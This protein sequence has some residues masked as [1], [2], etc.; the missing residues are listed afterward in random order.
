MKNNLETG[1]LRQCDRELLDACGDLNIPAVLSAIE[2]GADVNVEYEGCTPMFNAMLGD[3]TPPADDDDDDD[4]DGPSL[5]DEEV[6]ASLENTD[7]Q[8]IRV[9][10]ILLSHGAGIN[11]IPKG[12]YELLW[13]SVHNAPCVTE[14]LLKNGADPNLVSDDHTDGFVDT[15]L[16]HAWTDET[17]YHDDKRFAGY[18]TKIQRLLL[19]YGARPNTDRNITETSIDLTKFRSF[20][21]VPP[22]TFPQK[23][24]ALPSLSDAEKSLFKAC[25]ALDVAAVSKLLDDGCNPNI[26]DCDDDCATPLCKVTEMQAMGYPSIL[27]DKQIDHEVG[28]AALNGRAISIARELL[29]HGADPNIPKVEQEREE[30]GFEYLYGQTPLMLAA[31][32]SKNEEMTELLL[33]SGANPNF[34]CK[35]RDADGDTI[36]SLNGVDYHVDDPMEVNKIEQLLDCY[37]GCYNGIFDDWEFSLSDVDQALIYACQRLD[38]YGV[39]LAAKLGGDLAVHSRLGDCC[40]PVVAIY[41]APQLLGNRVRVQKWG[42]IESLVTDFVL[43]LLVGMKT[44]VSEK[45]VDAILKA[46]V[47]AGFEELMTALLSHHSLGGKFRDA[48]S[49]CRPDEYL[50]L[51]WPKD[52]R[53]RMAR[54]LGQKE[55]A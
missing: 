21:N 11:K 16:D 26:R 53:E 1:A 41:D 20:E 6:C 31:W 18:F 51:K 43:F 45:D 49:T 17:V 35:D 52:K 5:S 19:S 10:E 23:P 4:D 15:P 25:S 33:E 22:E 54:L 39:Q 47:S 46:C 55:D 36:Q 28:M 48:A 50:W 3:D 44:P 30:D 37:G 29:R 40:L 38:Y 24:G 32:L 42:N 9:F 34:R 14:F 13:Y 2:A 7:R 8:R 27:D 12:Q